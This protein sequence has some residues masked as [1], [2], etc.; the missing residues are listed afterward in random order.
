M[1]E[2]LTRLGYTL[3]LEKCSLVPSS[4][5]KYLGFLV[6][7]ARQAYIFPED[8]KQKFIQLRESI[9][10]KSEVD[11]NTLQRFCGKWISMCLAIP[12]CKLYCREVNAAISKCQRNSK[13]IAVSDSLREEI[14][15]ISR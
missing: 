6:D 15:E 8:K 12:G 9:L 2:L 7:S 4:C 14:F 10:A 11:F 1:V 3:A 5:K 13:N